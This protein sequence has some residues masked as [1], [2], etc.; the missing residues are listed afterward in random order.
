MKYNYK[1]IISQNLSTNFLIIYYLYKVFSSYDKMNLERERK[2]E[3]PT[4]LET[5]PFI[6]DG[7]L[8]RLFLL[9]PSFIR[10]SNRAEQIKMVR[11]H[12]SLYTLYRGHSHI[13]IWLTYMYATL[14]YEDVQRCLCIIII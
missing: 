1:K 9:Q 12:G 13:N 3:R 5:S 4:S 2:R 14:L 8:Q 6:I 11:A 7:F 10:E